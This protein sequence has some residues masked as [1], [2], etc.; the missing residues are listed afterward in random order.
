[1]VWNSSEQKLLPPAELQRVTSG[2]LLSMQEG[3][4][5]GVVAVRSPHQH[6]CR[7]AVAEKSGIGLVA[8]LKLLSALREKIAA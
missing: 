4:A 5:R 8:S 2:S 1:M 7:S 6:L 3:A